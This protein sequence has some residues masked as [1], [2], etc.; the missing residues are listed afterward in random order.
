MV[1]L[2]ILTLTEN[3][4][5]QY[6]DLTESTPSEEP[7]KLSQYLVVLAIPR[8]SVALTRTA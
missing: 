1:D 8:I 4:V 3:E 6:P 2:R 5:F 7:S